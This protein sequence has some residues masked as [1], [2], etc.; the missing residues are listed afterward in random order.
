MALAYGLVFQ[1][2]HPPNHHGM[3]KQKSSLGMLLLGSLLLGFAQC[4][5]TEVPT[6]VDLIIPERVTATQKGG[7]TL[8]DPS[9]GQSYEDLNILYHNR[10][11]G[12]IFT[13]RFA[14][15]DGLPLETI[16][17]VAVQI[18]N[19]EGGEAPPSSATATLSITD[20]MINPINPRVIVLDPMITYA[21]SIAGNGKA[22]TTLAL[23]LNRPGTYRWAW[24]ANYDQSVEET[25]YNNNCWTP[26]S[27]GIP[28]KRAEWGAELVVAPI[29]DKTYPSGKPAVELV[30]LS[31]DFEA[32]L[33]DPKRLEEFYQARLA[34]PSTP[35]LLGDGG[36]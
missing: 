6:A 1:S 11:T 31:P 30:P 25:D 24:C 13:S 19:Q 5:R 12:E 33:A 14:P 9:T 27:G 21:P 7:E 15:L 36:L 20:S 18:H 26:S 34:R 29:L 17:E 28:T 3:L 35:F 8:L 32:F 16:L 22:W 4:T 2:F 10:N 23:R